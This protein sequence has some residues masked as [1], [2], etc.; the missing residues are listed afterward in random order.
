MSKRP[1]LS[2]GP[3]LLEL[4]SKAPFDPSSVIDAFSESPSPCCETQR[5]SRS[6]VCLPRMVWWQIRTRRPRLL[7]RVHSMTLY[8]SKLRF[9]W[10]RKTSWLGAPSRGSRLVAVDVKTNAFPGR[11]HSGSKLSPLP[12]RSFAAEPRNVWATSVPSFASPGRMRTYTRFV[13]GAG[14]G[15]TSGRRFGSF[16]LVRARFVAVEVKAPREQSPDSETSKLGPFACCPR[17]LTDTRVIAP[18]SRSRTNASATALVSP[19]TRFDASE[20]N[21]RQWGLRFFESPSS[22]GR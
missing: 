2:R 17:L 16:A 18:V 19:G 7:L 6:S 14:A 13:P 11:D 20:M 4:L 1:F 12:G 8:F 21:A 9:A 3:R 22:A 15:V 5:V 10:R